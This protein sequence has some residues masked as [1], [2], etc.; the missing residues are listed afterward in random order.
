MTEPFQY[1]PPKNPVKILYQDKD[2]IVVDKPSGLLSVPGRSADRQDSMYLR[3]LEMF[4]LAQVV[5]RL[6]M[7]TSGLMVYAL[8]RKA[9][10]HLREQFQQRRVQKGYQA[11]VQGILSES[12]GVI[13]AP[14]GPDPSRPLRHCISSAGKASE[15]RFQVVE[16]GEECSLLHLQPITGRSHQLRVHLMSIGHPIIGDR[17]YAPVPIAN[18]STRLL[19]HA[20]E[21]YF[22]QPYSGKPLQFT[23]HSNFSAL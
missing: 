10:R 17:F 4:P 16:E 14:L 13:N 19:L 1:C 3:I 11:L 20:S 23:L 15:T 8:R 6:D 18:R 22:R 9:E 2:V 5:H 7:D 12:R 21:L